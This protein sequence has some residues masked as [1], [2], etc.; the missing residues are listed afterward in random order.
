[1][2]DIVDRHGTYLP[3]LDSAA[4]LTNI[5]ENAAIGFVIMTFDGRLLHA[6]RAFCAMVGFTEAELITI[7]VDG[8]MH[9]DD[10][11]AAEQSF[12]SIVTGQ[13]QSYQLERRYRRKD[14][15]YFHA[16]GAVS[17][18]RAR[19]DHELD[20][21]IIQITDV[22]A[23]KEAERKSFALHERLKLAVETSGAGV[24]D[25]DFTDEKYHWDARMHELYGLL[26]G[27]FSGRLADW[28]EMMH[29]GDVAR[30]REEWRRTMATSSHFSSEYRICRPS[31]EVR[32]IRALAQLVRDEDGAARRAVGTSW[33]VTDYKRLNEEMLE[34]KERLKITLASI[35]EAVICTDALAN[36][37]FVNSTAA[38]LTGWQAQA[39]IGKPL[40]DV[41][42]LVEE[43]TGDPAPHPVAQCF[44]HAPSQYR[45][46]GIFMLDLNGGVYDIQL[47]AAPVRRS[48]GEMIGS[49]VVF[50]D[51]TTDR[52]QRRKMTHSAHHDGLT[53][54]PNRA[55]FL[56][57]LERVIEEAR[58][59]STTHALCYIDLDRFKAV[60]DTGGHAAGDALLKEIAKIIAL[61]C[62]KK[63]IPARLGGDEF[64]LILRNTDL[65]EA[66][67]I[68]S[69]LVDAI[70][71]MEFRWESMV[72]RVGASIGIA[73]VSN[74]MSDSTVIL[75]RADLACYSAKS[76][77]RR[78]VHVFGADDRD[79][80]GS[81]DDGKNYSFGR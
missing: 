1:M 68:A 65:A 48:D 31:G 51:V 69:R 43:A 5:M 12:H 18:H 10:C 15:T 54:L 8:L 29:P 56:A 66:R 72:F 19:A 44:A 25:V 11:L 24:W 17:V 47:S 9:P 64:G 37:T 33:D 42:R 61:C 13:A 75:H 23:Q 6:N 45:A 67:A 55:A 58:K 20:I 27:E 21:A 22:T 46:S 39:A 26:P 38:T 14:G 50:Q 49:I 3:F 74:G 70:C 63:D 34:E 41:L 79:D 2:R 73:A 78:S 32:H 57:G 35:G 7:G 40:A 4:L 16:L 30:V 60:N 76:S 71:E 53:G 77:G 59:N 52:A 81:W 28:E 80:C 62:S 36:V